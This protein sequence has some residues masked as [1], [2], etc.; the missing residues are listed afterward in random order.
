MAEPVEIDSSRRTAHE[1]LQGATELARTELSRTM[2]A[3]AFSGGVTI[4]SLLNWG[5]VKA[6][7]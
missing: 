2:R 5:Q 6:G 7:K 3:L 1:I 4:V